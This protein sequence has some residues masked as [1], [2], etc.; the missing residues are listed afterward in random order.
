MQVV[1][2]V[3]LNVPEGSGKE[4]EGHEYETI[5][6]DLIEDQVERGLISGVSHVT[7]TFEDIV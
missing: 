6:N 5:V 3:I 7:T 1:I 2:Q 4:L